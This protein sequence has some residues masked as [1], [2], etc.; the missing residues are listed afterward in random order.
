MPKKT[1]L[2]ALGYAGL[3]AAD[4]LLASRSGVLARGARRVTKPLLMPTLMSAYVGASGGL[5]RPVVRRT[6]AAQALACAGD[7][8]LL[9]KGER[10]FLTGLGSFF[11]SHVAYVAAFSAVRDT[12]PA[13]SRAGEKVAAGI[14]VA[15]GPAMAWAAGR[16]D[17]K[18]RLPVAAYAAVLAGM[19]AASTSVDHR[20]PAAGRRMVV[21]GAVLFLVS[22]TLL[23]T[24]EFLTE[25]GDRRLDVGVMATY[26][27]A[28]GLIAAGMVQVA[29]EDGR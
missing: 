4:T 11:A 12:D 15:T 9:G 14:W 8:A 25:D 21:A 17:P 29:G 7:V 27:A 28:Q 22:D 2:T 10:A 20:A 1:V 13:R 3:A 19:F 18:L 23:A 6:A 26:T 24:R 16:T 5:H